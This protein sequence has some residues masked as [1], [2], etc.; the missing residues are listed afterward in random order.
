MLSGTGTWRRYLAVARERAALDDQDWLSGSTEPAWDVGRGAPEG[1]VELL[2]E[3]EPGDGPSLSELCELFEQLDAP[4]VPA[5]L[6]IGTTDDGQAVAVLE[7]A[8]GSSLEQ[9]LDRP[10]PLSTGEIVT[11]LAALA[12][13]MGELHRHG[14]SVGPF[15]CGDVRLTDLGRPIFT[16]WQAAA[17]LPAEQSRATV[18]V[19]RDWRTFEAVADLV[20]AQLPSVTE[21]PAPLERELDRC[22]SGEVDDELGR[23]L[24]DALFSWQDPSEVIDPSSGEHGPRRAVLAAPLERTPSWDSFE[25]TDGDALGDADAPIA[26]ESLLDGDTVGA[27]MGGRSAARSAR[28]PGNRGGRPGGN[29]EDSRRRSQRA[30]HRTGSG[31]GWLTRVRTPYRVAAVAGVIMCVCAVS[32]WTLDLETGG[33]SVAAN[34]TLAAD[35]ETT[36]PE[37]LA[38][39]GTSPAATA[40]QEDAEA[41]DEATPQE[42]QSV[43]LGDDPIAAA[44]ALVAGRAACLSASAPGCL[45]ELYQSDAPGLHA[46]LARGAGAE[47]ELLGL[48]AATLRDRYGDFAVIDLWSSD[49]VQGAE[50]PPASLTIARGEA[51]WRLRD[52]RVA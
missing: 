8:A 39:Q 3:G 4:G 21:L 26:A 37:G 28:L 45:E 25:E 27:G 20:L 31:G 10:T 18:S 38:L 9:L 7:A 51:G 5:V 49:A 35:S 46:D 36:P 2:I 19:A 14:V 40:A 32:L 41:P 33:E 48:T 44:L 12:E 22:L 1:V 29:R 16:R 42:W 11:I 50:T 24:L 43:A 15:G 47:D 30:R 23:R 17:K 34:D 13:T 6:D 52:V